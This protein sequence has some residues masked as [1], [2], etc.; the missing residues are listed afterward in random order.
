MP[1]LNIVE[2]VIALE[3]V[4]VFGNLTTEQLARI[5][6]I[7][8]EAKSAPGAVILDGS[9]PI[10]ALYVIVE[11]A[12]ELSHGDEPLTTGREGKVLGAWA[13]FTDN[14]SIR[15]TARAIEDTRLLCIDREEFYELL[16]DHSEITSAIFAAL[17]K[18]FRGAVEQ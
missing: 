2:K 11:G 16:T 1:E 13:L 6:A 17:V 14:D 4:E 12:V 15:V 5:A 3:A 18:R 8:R 7:A 10:D 9:K